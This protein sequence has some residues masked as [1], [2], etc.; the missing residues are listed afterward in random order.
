MVVVAAIAVVVL[1]WAVEDGHDTVRIQSRYSGD[2]VRWWC[3][4]NRGGSLGLGCGG[5]S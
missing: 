2:T 3:G 1:V 4:N 5:R